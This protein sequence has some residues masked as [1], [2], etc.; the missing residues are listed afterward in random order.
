MNR[1]ASSRLPPPQGGA[2]NDFLDY[3]KG[4]LIFLVV[5]G[6]L[7]QLV[8]YG[9]DT[10]F[11]K[12]PLFT[13]IYTFHMPLFMAVSGFVSFG[14][15]VRS[16]FFTCVLRRF[17][18]VIIPAICWPLLGLI[19]L[20]LWSLFRADTFG[21]GVQAF[22]HSLAS[23]RPGLW[24]LWA[25]F[26][27]TVVVAALKRFRLDRLQ[28]FALAA[29]LVLFLPEGAN[30]YLFKYTLP[31]FCLGYALAKGDQIRVPK[32]FSPLSLITIFA[33][34]IG[35]YLLWT[36]D[37]YVYTTRMHP[38]FSNLSNI[39]LRF[40]AGVVTSVAFV[41]LLA[42]C[43]RVAKLPVLSLWGRRSLDIYIIHA[44]FVTGLASLD[45][46][47]KY[48]PWFSFVVAPVLAAIIC[49]LSCVAGLGLG[50][51]PVARTLLLGHASKA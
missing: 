14:M 21:H 46:P 10:L 2:R 11:Y 3:L 8:G 27:S 12:D 40:V 51:I 26:G 7:I 9:D 38:S 28:F 15:I 35:C 34:S 24:F 20:F 33:L 1:P 29:V 49:A 18:Q 19:A 44:C 23:F 39:G 30:L 42:G 36:N 4:A 32:S 48:S 50:R 13:A 22:K 25:I 5:C 41:L 31:F 17:R 37:T 45:N 16:D 6:H 47:L 43:Y